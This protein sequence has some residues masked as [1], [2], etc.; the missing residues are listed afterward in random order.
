MAHEV[1]TM[2]YANQV[3][4]HG[5]GNVVDA[6][7]SVEEMQRAAGLDWELKKV[8][9]ALGF[10]EGTPSEWAGTKVPKKFAWVRSSDRRIMSISG[11]AWR[12]LQPAA[13]LDF[14]RNYVE[15][16]AATLE[17]AGSLREGK[18][19][20]GLARLHHDFEVG[21]G[22]RVNGYLLITSPNEVGT[23][24]TIRTTTVRVVCANTMAMA[25]REGAGKTHYRQNHMKEFN[26]E[27]A[28]EVVGSAHEQLLQAERNAKTLAKLRLSASDAMVKVLMPVFAPDVV[29]AGPEAIAAAQLSE[30]QPAWLMEIMASMARSPGAAEV[31][32]TGW[33]VLGGVTH[34]ADHVSGRNAASRMKRSWMGDRGRQK[35]QVEKLLLEL[36]Q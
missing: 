16:G 18:V 22:D 6:K 13:T 26:V 28:K 3:P 5:L 32:G 33:G 24:I 17:T 1:E 12:P 11:A 23:A 7:S 10:G 9:L 25:N 14:M 21:T 31:N 20:W 27:A 29:T 19:V 30:N 2:A 8:P 15:A 34:W 35:L 36:A 4:W